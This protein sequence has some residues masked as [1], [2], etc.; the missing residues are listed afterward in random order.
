M[1]FAALGLAASVVAASALLPSVA[2]AQPGTVAAPAHVSNVES[3]AYC[4]RKAWRRGLCG[5]GGT[6]VR[7]PFTEVDTTRG[8]WV[9][10]PFVRVYS[11]RYG[12]W[13]RAPF[14]NLWNPH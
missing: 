14:V 9:A 5:N 7:A 2:S 10:A 3:V 1:R 12:T 11:G 13:V 6:Y 8:T 4:T